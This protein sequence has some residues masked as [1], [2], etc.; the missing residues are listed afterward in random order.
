M[1]EESRNQKLMINTSGPI[2]MRGVMV[3]KTPQPRC[4]HCGKLLADHNG[5]TRACPL[6][7]KHRT[8]GY[9]QYSAK[10]VFE[11]KPPRKST[12]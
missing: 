3:R 1:S 6:G 4:K 10:T 8:I 7:E 5:K 12:P 11:P 2:W 9:T